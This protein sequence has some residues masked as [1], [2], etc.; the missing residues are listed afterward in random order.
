MFHSGIKDVVIICKTKRMVLMLQFMR[1]SLNFTTWPSYT[2]HQHHPSITFDS[3]LA[4]SED[5]G[6]GFSSKEE[7]GVIKSLNWPMN[8]KANTECMW[9]IAV[10]VGE[11][12]TLKF[13]H[14]DLEAKDFLTS[15][16]YDNIVVY[17]INGETNEQLAKHGKFVFGVPASLPVILKSKTTQ[18]FIVFP[19]WYWFCSD[20]KC[21]VTI[22]PLVSSLCHVI[23]ICKNCL[24]PFC[25]TK[26]PSAIQTKGN[27]L[28]MRF[29]TDL[30]TEAKGF[31]AYWT[32]DTSLP[33]PTEP[34]AQ[35]NPWDDIEIG[36]T[37]LW[38]LC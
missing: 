3:P 19:Y 2:F 17:D 7:T 25:G 16:C 29:H 6:C 35:P 11:N 36:E 30:F 9:N 37:D 34:P 21:Y 38:Q 20:P 24:G 15:K 14:F 12:I 10:P 27:R 1:N 32:T 4:V 22:S 28:V 18:L 5:Q 8:Y 13:T 33:A 31:R 26:L 23:F